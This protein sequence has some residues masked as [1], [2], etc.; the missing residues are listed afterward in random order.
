MEKCFEPKQGREP[1]DITINL[2]GARKAINDYKKAIGDEA[3]VFELMMVYTERGVS[4][5][6]EF[7]SD[8]SAYYTSIHKMIGQILTLLQNDADRQV[9]YEKRM[10]KLIKQ[11]ELQWGI[12]N[13]ID[14]ELLALYL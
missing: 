6:V 9:K 8:N 4:F 12:K 7:S 5:L 1:W 3:G 10:R 14:N 11:A 13:Y 2:A